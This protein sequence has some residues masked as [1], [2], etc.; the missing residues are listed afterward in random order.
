MNKLCSIRGPSHVVSESISESLQFGNEHLI[1]PKYEQITERTK[2]MTVKIVML[3]LF[4][5]SSF[6]FF[7]RK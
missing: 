2:S 6:M 3:I 4:F 1:D 7:G 5:F